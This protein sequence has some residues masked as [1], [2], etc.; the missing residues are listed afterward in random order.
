[1]ESESVQVASLYLTGVSSNR[2][3]INF[4]QNVFKVVLLATPTL[5]SFWVCT[6]A[7]LVVSHYN[8]D[9]SEGLWYLH[10]HD[11]PIVH[12]DLS[13]NNILLTHQLMAKSSYSSQSYTSRQ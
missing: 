3:D 5:Y 2:K 6:I 1:M 10:S 11:L 7:I 9:V 4:L 12:Q 8:Q 13:P